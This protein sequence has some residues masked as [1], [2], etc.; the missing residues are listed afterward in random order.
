MLHLIF[1]GTIDNKLVERIAPDDAVVLLD[2]AV[3]RSLRLG[4]CAALVAKFV[5]QGRC[6]VLQEHLLIRGIAAAEIIDGIEIIDYAGL[7]ELTVEHSVIKT[8]QSS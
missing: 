1:L 4:D 8:W 6:F 2:D 5:Q 3:F 7:V